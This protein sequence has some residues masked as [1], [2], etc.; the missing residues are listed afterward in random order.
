MKRP[1]SKNPPPEPYHRAR[2]QNPRAVIGGIAAAGTI[3]WAFIRF[4]PQRVIVEGSSMEPTLDPG[5]WALAVV[6]PRFHIGD[7]VVVEHPDRN[8]Y[9]MVK[10]LVAGPG[11]RVK[12]RSL[13]PDEWW[14]QG[15]HRGGS[16]DSRSFGPVP[17]S[18]LKARIVAV[19]GPGRR[20]R[21]VRSTAPA[22]RHGIYD[23]DP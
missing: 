23:G 10:R 17:S 3:A 18:A 7:V 19:Y 16:T 14:V 2:K 4:K 9:E 12:E 15:D 6:P 22:S 1:P 13:D 8:G 21:L 11:D 5:D 20:R